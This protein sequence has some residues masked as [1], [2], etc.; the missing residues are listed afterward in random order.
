MI[1]SA[2]NTGF[3]SGLKLN[4]SM[5]YFLAS[6]GTP[7]IKV[8]REREIQR[9]RERERERERERGGAERISER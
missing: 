4:R 2:E 1:L 6:R 3:V 8:E 9:D 7:F 5:N